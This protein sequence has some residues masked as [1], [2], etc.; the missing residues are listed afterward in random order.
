[1]QGVIRTAIAETLESLGLPGA[2]F[3]V[4]HPAEVTHGDYACNVAMVLAKQ[5]GKSQRAVAEQVA[6]ALKDQIEYVDRIEIA[7]PGFLNFYLI[8]DFF[9]AEIERAV[10]MGDTWADKKVLVEYTDA[11]PFKEF[12]VG[13]LFTNAVGE[14]IARLFMMNGA[15]TKRV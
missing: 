7:G 12:H 6:E 4:E 10:S 1:M 9:S 8:R 3:A 5:V 11:N 2:T 15:D 14:S 13:H